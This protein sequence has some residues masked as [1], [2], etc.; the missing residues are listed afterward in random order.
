MKYFIEV[1]NFVDSILLWVVLAFLAVCLVELVIFLLKKKGGPFDTDGYFMCIANN[2]MITLGLYVLACLVVGFV[3]CIKDQN[4][5]FWTNYMNFLQNSGSKVIFGIIFVVAC[6]F[7]LFKSNADSFIG[8][9]IAAALSAAVATLVAVI[10]GFL[11]YVV[12]AF[13]IIVL[14]LIWFVVSGFFQSIFGFMVK[15]WQMSVIVLGCPGVIYGAS[16]AFFNYI[17]S[18]KNEVVHK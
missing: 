1:V 14:K 9:L 3:N 18:F 16:C 12:V 17:K 5:H 6:I 15:Y 2:L 7:F 8:R 13:V 4:W 11:V 10:A